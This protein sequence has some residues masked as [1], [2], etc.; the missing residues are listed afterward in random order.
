MHDFD[1]RLA[2]NDKY[3]ND[4]LF[5]RKHQLL[6]RLGAHVNLIFLGSWNVTGG[7]AQKFG[8]LKNPHLWL[9]ISII[10]NITNTIPLTSP[11]GRV[12]WN[13]VWRWPL[14][15]P[16]LHPVRKIFK[17]N[18]TGGKS[19]EEI[20][21]S[22]MADEFWGKKDGDPCPSRFRTKLNLFNRLSQ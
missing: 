6:I 12:I 7:W 17:L 19:W 14:C 21:R 1:L 2:L 16:Y 5:S 18:K 22:N 13:V 4:E 10:I 9:R 15:S 3:P 20:H 8:K 11:W